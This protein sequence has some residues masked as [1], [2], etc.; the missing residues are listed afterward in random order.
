MISVISPVPEETRFEIRSP[1]EPKDICEY[2]V[3]A[4]RVEPSIVV[5]S[6]G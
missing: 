2:D 6:I 1:F 4:L 3:H 5:G